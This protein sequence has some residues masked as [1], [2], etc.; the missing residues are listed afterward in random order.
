MYVCFCV[1]TCVYVCTCKD[2]MS[3]LGQLKYIKEFKVKR[4]RE[5][6]MRR[7]VLRT[8]EQKYTNFTSCSLYF[9]LRAPQLHCIFHTLI[10]CLHLAFLITLLLDSLNLI[11]LFLL[12]MPILNHTRARTHTF[13]LAWLDLPYKFIR[14]H[15]GENKDNLLL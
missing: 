11:C 2:F 8:I 14:S 4:A 9:F 12:Y 10:F 5:R 6:E 7:P 13:K 1:A 3:Y 15:S